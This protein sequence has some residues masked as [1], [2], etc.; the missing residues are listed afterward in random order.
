MNGLLTALNVLFP[1]VTFPYISRV[2]LPLG[3]GKVAFATSLVTYFMIFAS[4]GVPTYGIREVAKV[5]DD[6]EALSKLVQELLVLN[7]MTC[8]ISYILFFC[9][10]GFVPRFQGEW[11]L[12]AVVSISIFFNTIGVEGL[13]KGIEQYAYITI[14]SAIFKLIALGA[15]F[16]LVTKPEDYIIY[17]GISIFASVGSNICNFINLRKHRSWTC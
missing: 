2:L 7:L 15:M 17:G 5:R 11:T 14:R 10:I 9:L 8:V 6:K 3:T 1:L 13:Y 16:L 4:L 12:Y